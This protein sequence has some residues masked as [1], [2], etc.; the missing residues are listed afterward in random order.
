MHDIDVIGGG[1]AGLIAAAECAEAGAR[2]RVLEARSRFGGRAASTGQPFVANLGPHAL[3]AGGSLWEW[4]ERRD[5]HRPYQRPRSP[6][7]RFRWQG[8]TKRLPPAELLRA[9]RYGRTEAPV[10]VDLRTWMTDRAGSGAAQAASGFAGPLTFDHDPGRLPAAFVWHRVRRILLH[11]SSPA[12]YVVGGWGALVDRLVAHDRSLGVALE[13]NSRVDSLDGLDGRP[14]IVA[15]EPGAAR[16][17]L[18]DDSLRPETPRVALLDVAVRSRRGDP[19]I[20]FDLDGAVFVDRF[21]AVDRTLAPN[22]EELVQA[23]VGLLPGEE[24]A[25]AIVRIETVLDGGFEGWRDRTTWRRQAIVRES[26]GALDPVGHT[27]RDRAPI[28]YADG[29]WLAGDWVAAPGHLAEV[30]CA[31]AIEAA[32]G[33]VSASRPR[34]AA[35]S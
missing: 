9:A 20:V 28:A 29:V 35:A 12:R 17:L 16:R 11:Q 23:S 24:L 13:T 26:T 14:V 33:A 6:A 3:Y 22:G 32:A 30:S 1:L 18:G 4:L 8:E 31:S 10:D 15:I 7:I 5:L 34:A 27:W 19:Y 2:V 21:T 25:D